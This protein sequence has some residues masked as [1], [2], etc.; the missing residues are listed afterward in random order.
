MSGIARQ[1]TSLSPAAIP[2]HD[3]CEVL[4]KF[5]F[6]KPAEQRRVQAFISPQCFGKANS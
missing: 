6:V 4:G 5:I 1:V 3:N 2:I